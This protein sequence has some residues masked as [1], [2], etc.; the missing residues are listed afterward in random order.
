MKNRCII[1]T[2]CIFDWTL[3][4]TL[5]TCSFQVNVVSIVVPS[6]FIVAFVLTTVPYISTF[7]GLHY[8]I[9]VHLLPFHYFPQWY[10]R[11]FQKSD[12]IWLLITIVIS[13]GYSSARFLYL[14]YYVPYAVCELVLRGN[15]HLIE[16][17]IFQ[18]IESFNNELIH[19]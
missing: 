16:I 9:V 6:T 5:L 18:L 1:L 4:A 17:V 3:E 12:L 2:A 14:F 10:E 13:H 8:Y 11:A 19:I 15:D 7:S